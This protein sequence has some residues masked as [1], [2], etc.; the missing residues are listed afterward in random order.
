M[1]EKI[2]LIGTSEHA[3]MIIE[4]IED[5]ARFQL[6]GFTTNRQEEVGKTILGYKV[7]CLDEEIPS[8]L[9][10]NKDIVGYFLGVGVVNGMKYR[11]KI[12]QELDKWLPAVNIIHPSSQVSKYSTMGVGNI[13]EGF[14]KVANG[15]VMGSHCIVNSFTAVNHGQIIGD[16][17]LLAGSVSLA[18]KRI[19]SHTII[20]DGASIA[21]KKSVGT[22]CIIGDGAVVTSDIPD[23]SIAY[24]NPARII[25]KNE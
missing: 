23:N 2:I 12:I 11:W 20:A 25:R 14:T 17:V 6:F 7:V 8:L 9:R 16:N 15:V 22:N 1:K 21:F 18:G 13:L 5:Q 19:G 24:G 3:Q 10:E 4:N